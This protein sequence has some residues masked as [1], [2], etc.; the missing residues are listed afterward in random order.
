[1]RA[2]SVPF[3]RTRRAGSQ[4]K[5]YDLSQKMIERTE[6]VV[7][8]R[9]LWITFLAHLQPC[10]PTYNNEKIGL[11]DREQSLGNTAQVNKHELLTR[12]GCAQQL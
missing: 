10:R 2:I 4:Y 3:Q 6:E 12:K 11:M 7:L 1:V 9:A 5:G 8:C